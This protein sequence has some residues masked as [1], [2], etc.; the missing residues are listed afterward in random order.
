MALEQVVIP[1]DEMKRYLRVE[2]N[3]DDDLITLLIESAKEHAEAYMNHDFTEVDSEG[4]VRFLTPPSSVKL[5]CMRMVNSWYDYRDDTTEQSS[6]GDRSRNVGE[7]PWDVERMLWPHRR[8]A[9][10]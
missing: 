10:T 8:L 5:A 2:H 3:A 4:V 7:I 9:G 6:L 1:L